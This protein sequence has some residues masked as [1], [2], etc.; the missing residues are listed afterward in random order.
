MNKILVI[1]PLTFFPIGVLQNISFKTTLFIN[2][3]IAFREKSSTE[4]QITSPKIKTP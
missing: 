4:K 2:I 3:T 1:V